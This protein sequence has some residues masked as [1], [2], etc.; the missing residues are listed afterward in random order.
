MPVLHELAT[1]MCRVLLQGLDTAAPELHLAGQAPLKGVHEEN[2]GSLMFFTLH[3]RPAA[4]HPDEEHG[5]SPAGSCQAASRGC[6][7]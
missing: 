3:S 5:A 2:L 1:A 7:S 4:P 6:L